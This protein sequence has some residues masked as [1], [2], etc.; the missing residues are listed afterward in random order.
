MLM[1]LILPMIA[2]EKNPPKFIQSL[3]CLRLRPDNPD[4]VYSV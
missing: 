2:E 4:S 3:P 1:R